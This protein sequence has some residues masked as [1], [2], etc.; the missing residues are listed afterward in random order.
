VAIREMRPIR[1]IDGDSSTAERS[2]IFNQINQRDW[3]LKSAD[4]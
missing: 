3:R 1:A 4:P 2:A